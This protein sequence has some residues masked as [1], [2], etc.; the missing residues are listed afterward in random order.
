MFGRAGR[1]ALLPAVCSC[2][3]IRCGKT[4]GLEADNRSV[5]AVGLFRFDIT[6]RRILRYT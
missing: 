4:H 1:G 3:D 5:F 6:I 2:P